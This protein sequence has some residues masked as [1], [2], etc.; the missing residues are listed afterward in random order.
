VIWPDYGMNKSEGGG[1]PGQKSN[2]IMDHGFPLFFNLQLS[3]FKG[4]VSLIPRQSL[5]A[6]TWRDTG[7][8]LGQL[9]LFLQIPFPQ[10][11]DPLG[12]GGAGPVHGFH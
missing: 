4:E 7:Q 6:T 11:H 5:F 9:D 10:D 8:G 2:F 1:C 12:L 3:V